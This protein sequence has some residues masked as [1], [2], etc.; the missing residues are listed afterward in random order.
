MKETS[1]LSPVMKHLLL[2]RLQ[3]QQL[4]HSD[5]LSECFPVLVHVWKARTR[6]N[7]ESGRTLRSA[8]VW[9]FA[10]LPL[11]ASQRSL[12]RAK[13]T[14]SGWAPASVATTPADTLLT[15]LRWR[16]MGLCVISH[17]RSL[18][19]PFKC[20]P[21]FRADEKVQCLHRWLGTFEAA[22]KKK[23]ASAL[24]FVAPFITPPPSSRIL[25]STFKGNN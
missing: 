17:S 8:E 19:Q 16:K 7:I 1:Q 2:F 18:S 22:R 15:H 12:A 14:V 13:G 20:F 25:T 4:R 10:L 23:T 24:L 3:I 9:L 6:P 5:G 21:L 11:F